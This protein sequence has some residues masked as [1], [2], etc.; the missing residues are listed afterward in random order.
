[1]EGYENMG[2]FRNLLDFYWNLLEII[3]KDRKLQELSW[4]FDYWEVKED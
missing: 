2:I 1:M 4:K 3:G